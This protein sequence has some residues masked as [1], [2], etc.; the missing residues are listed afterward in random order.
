[1]Q[2]IVHET[3]QGV[4]FIWSNTLYQT[5]KEIEK[6]QKS[7]RKTNCLKMV[8][9]SNNVLCACE[10]IDSL[11]LCASPSPLWTLNTIGS[12]IA[13]LTPIFLKLP[14]MSKNLYFQFYQFWCKIFHV[15]TA[16]A[17]S[18]I[19]PNL[20][21]LSMLTTSPSSVP[22]SLA[23]SLHFAATAPFNLV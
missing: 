11:T 1:M 16:S 17:L 14:S 5:V 19:E 3:S 18:T 21:S 4:L 2:Q 6:Q 15:R 7:S 23:S 8:F 22:L 12:V 13:Y 9:C 10:C 20:S